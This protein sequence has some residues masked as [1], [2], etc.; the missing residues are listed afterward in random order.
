MGME[1]HRHAA[2]GRMSGESFRAFQDS[3][4]DYERWKTAN[5]WHSQKLGP[6]DDL[7]LPAFGVR[8]AVVDLYEGTPL[9]PRSRPRPAA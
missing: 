6:G 7:S 2:A 4:P 8:C 3:R 9:Q 1:I 5:G